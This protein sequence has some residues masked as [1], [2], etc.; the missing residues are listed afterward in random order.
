MVEKKGDTGSLYVNMSLLC[1]NS[2][3]VDMAELEAELNDI[4]KK[5]NAGKDF[6]PKVARMLYGDRSKG[7]KA[8]DLK[9]EA[10]RSEAIQY[11]VSFKK[12]CETLITPNFKDLFS[13]EFKNDE[14]RI[15]EI[16]EA[17]HAIID[18][19]ENDQVILV[20]KQALIDLFSL[21]FS[22]KEVQ[23]KCGYF[24]PAL[25]SIRLHQGKESLPVFL[26]RLEQLAPKKE[27]VVAPEPLKAELQFGGR[28]F[29]AVKEEPKVPSGPVNSISHRL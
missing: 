16:D 29:A 5:L 3:P 7:L 14:S 20:S 19:T 18:L 10:V 2:K 24:V 13:K 28:L 12:E 21:D 22:K 6:Y 26:S 15:P 23:D 1:V 9:N 11:I 25:E 4:N 8:A 17:L 27:A